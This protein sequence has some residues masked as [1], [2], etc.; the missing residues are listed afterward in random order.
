MS[1][2]HHIPTNNGDKPLCCLITAVTSHSMDCQ[3]TGNGRN[4]GGWGERM[5]QP[6][7]GGGHRF[8]SC[9]VRQW[10]DG[11]S[12][13]LP[14]IEMISQPVYDRLNRTIIYL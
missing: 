8:E 6:S 10:W 9:R 1:L 14:A 5:T 11:G 4:V 2:P 3:K 12:Q 7:E 13:S